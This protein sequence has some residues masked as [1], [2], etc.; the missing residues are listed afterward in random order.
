MSGARFGNASQ[1][2]HQ[3][4]P[5]GNCRYPIATKH[6]PGWVTAILRT[7]SVGST[8]AASSIYLRGVDT[9]SRPTIPGVIVPWRAQT[10]FATLVNQ[11]FHPP[12]AGEAKSAI[13]SGESPSE[14]TLW[15]QVISY[16]MLAMLASYFRDVPAGTHRFFRGSPPY[17][18][19][20]AAAAGVG[21]LVAVEW[22]GKLIVSVV[23]EPFFLGSDAHRDAVARLPDRDFSGDKVD[24]HVDNAAVAVWPSAPGS[25]PAVIWCTSAPPASFDGSHK[26]F[27][28]ICC[29]S[30]GAPFLRNV[31]DVYTALAAALAGQRGGDGV[32]PGAITPA[33]LL[34][35]AGELCVL[36]PW[37]DG[38]DALPDD[39]AVGGSAVE[40]I[41]LAILWLA[42]HRLLYIDLREPNV[43]IADSHAVAGAGGASVGKLVALVDY[44]DCVILATPPSSAEELVKLLI[45]HDAAFAQDEGSPGA[46]P[47][48]VA[49]LRTH[50]SSQFFLPSESVLG[51]AAASAASSGGMPA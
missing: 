31:H 18:F 40:P 13:S 38:R 44:D 50:W 5:T 20:L 10:E 21:Y 34:Y 41:A 42:Q 39:L 35:G 19:G 28:V 1:E 49:A 48:V 27:K 17:A 33:E 12:F 26:F 29:E 36:M 45:K 23:S 25:R 3:P 6:V 32:R 16:C 8:Q 11:L 46:R 14:A 22:V 15:N 43:R 24:L 30:F 2:W 4:T 9:S 51:T 47:A 7:A 37:V